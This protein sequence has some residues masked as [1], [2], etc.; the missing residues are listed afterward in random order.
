VNFIENSLLMLLSEQIFLFAEPLLAIIVDFLN[1]FIK[2]QI[3]IATSLVHPCL[4]VILIILK[5]KVIIISPLLSSKAFLLQVT[6]IKAFDLS[7]IE[8]KPFPIVG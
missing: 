4:V 8:F 3:S 6:E 7:V 5:F 2:Y 1:S